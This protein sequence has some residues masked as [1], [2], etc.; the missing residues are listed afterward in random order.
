M[1]QSACK[2][3]G[4]PL[5][6]LGLRSSACGVSTPI[7]HAVSDTACT[8]PNKAGLFRLCQLIVFV[9]SSQLNTLFKDIFS[10]RFPALTISAR[11]KTKSCPSAFTVVLSG[12]YSAFIAQKRLD[13]LRKKYLLLKST[14]THHVKNTFRSKVLQRIA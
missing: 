2:G 11:T 8:K 6:L 10:F 13:T 1:T 9:V 4:Y 7:P 5:L 14:P 12:A 3:S